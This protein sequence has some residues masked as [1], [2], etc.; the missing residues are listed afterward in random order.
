MRLFVL[1]AAVASGYWTGTVTTP[2]GALPIGI[3]IT[4]GAATLDAPSL[5]YADKPLMFGVSDH[6]VHFELDVG[7]ETAAAE[8]SVSGDRL[9][10][11][12]SLGAA[13]FPL[14]LT[15]STRPDKSYRTEAVVLRSGDV[16]L[17]KSSRASIRLTLQT[18]PETSA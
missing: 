4:D 3:A 11:V 5:G 9:S 1:L 14:A 13:K 6:A 12:V 16:R 10:G 15:R 2:A 18:T 17:G 8:A 7:G